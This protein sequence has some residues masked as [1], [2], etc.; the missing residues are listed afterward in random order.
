MSNPTI[1]NLLAAVLTG[2]FSV[3]LLDAVFHLS[4]MI[5]PGVS[6]IYNALGT[7]IAPNLVTVVIFDFRAYDTLGES[8]ILLT[9]GLVV[10]L[11]FGRGLLGDKR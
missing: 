2:I 6:Y 11:I 8:I 4:S 7:Q 10:L 3:T 1:R 9:A 5:N